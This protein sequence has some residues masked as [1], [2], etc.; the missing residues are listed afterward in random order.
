MEEVVN[1]LN[2]ISISFQLCNNFTQLML[3][4]SQVYIS[5]T[6][7]LEG[8]YKFV[9]TENVC[10]RQKEAWQTPQTVYTLNQH[11]LPSRYSHICLSVNMKISNSEN[12]RAKTAKFYFT[13][14]TRP[15]PPRK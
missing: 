6:Q 10:E 14:R 1:L 2:P 12:V 9:S 8:Y 4:V 11:Q 13:F 15:F 3:Q 5:A 7:R